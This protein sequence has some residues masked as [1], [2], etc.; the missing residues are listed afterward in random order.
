L[1]PSSGLVL[2]LAGCGGGSGTMITEPPLAKNDT[3]AASALTPNSVSPGK[4]ATS[5]SPA[6]SVGVAPGK[7][8]QTLQLTTT[9]MLT[10]S[11]QHI[12]IIFQE[13][14]STDNLFH[15]PVLIANG[16]DIASSGLNSK[17]QII[18]LTAGPLA[19]S[20]DLGRSRGSFAAMYDNGKMDGADKIKTTCRSSCPPNP[21]FMYVNSKDVQPY[22]TLAEQYTFGDR[23][24]A[25]QFI[26]SGTSAPTATSTS[27]AAENPNN[28]SM[29]GCIA[30]LTNFVAIVDSSLRPPHVDRRVGRQGHQLALLHSQRRR[31]RR[32]LVR[33]GCDS[34]SLSVQDAEWSAGLHRA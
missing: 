6:D 21:Q 19:N 32:H 9:A 3:L 26:I 10:A 8:A 27:F 11:I 30:P 24:P 4:R 7:A 15:D 25:R 18:P 2:A 28:I 33:S 23:F 31:C 5:M 1:P 14:R 34:A 13:N 29:V 16:A 22:F 17:G 20:Y 12:V